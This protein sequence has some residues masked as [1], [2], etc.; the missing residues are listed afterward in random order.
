MRNSLP[1]FLLLALA[2]PAQAQDKR[3]LAFGDSVTFGHGDGAVLCAGV[4]ELC[5]EGTPGG[6]PL[7][8]QSSLAGRGVDATFENHGCCGERTDAGMTRID[9]VLSRGG[10]V[11]VIMEGTNDV[12]SGVGYETTVFNLNEMARK[13]EVAGIQPLLASIVPR[14]PD[15]GTDLLNG[16]T[17]TISTELAEA[18]AQ[19]DWPF[20]DPFSAIFGRLDFFERHYSDQFHPNASGYDIINQSMIFPAIDAATRTDLCAQAPTGPCQESATVLCLNDRRFRVNAIWENFEGGTGVG[21][22][23]P[24]TNDT[25][26]FYWFDPQNLELAIKVLDGRSE[27]DFFWVFFGALS[28][29]KFSVFVTDTVTGECKEY[30]NPLGTFASVGDTMAF[31]PF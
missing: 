8:L 27:N 4:G 6:Y 21:T 25:G 22:A 2:M 16:K 10:D 31:G 12:S 20:A 23:V 7:R 17:R 28:N 19:E 15:S 30:F 5:A 3:F 1:V 11:I 9:G 14:G 24:E 18:A 13:A 26:A 29:V